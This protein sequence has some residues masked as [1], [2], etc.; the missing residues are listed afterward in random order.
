[1]ILTSFKMI[2][3]Q[4]K[5]NL[6]ESKISAYEDF[7]CEYFSTSTMALQEDMYAYPYIVNRLKSYEYLL[8]IPESA[9]EE[10]FESLLQL[11]QVS[12]VT[13]DNV[14]I[15]CHSDYSSSKLYDIASKYEFKNISHDGYELF[16]QTTNAILV[17]SYD[18]MMNTLCLLPYES[19]HSRYI[20]QLFL[21][22]TN[23]K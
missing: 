11:F 19:N 8:Y 10:C 6:A 9:C 18:K 16:P 1:M 12:D 2:K 14:N 17:F 22:I 5:L 21:S 15:L 20:A 13:S 23:F 4:N 7:I 3:T